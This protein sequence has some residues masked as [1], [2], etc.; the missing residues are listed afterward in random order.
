MQKG[1]DT[2]VDDIIRE[3][4]ESWILKQTETFVKKLIWKLLRKK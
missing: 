1:D 3:V 4:D 2:A